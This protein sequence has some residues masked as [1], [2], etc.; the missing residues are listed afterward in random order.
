MLLV[1]FCFWWNVVGVDC[2]LCIVFYYCMV[3]QGGGGIDYVFGFGGV[4]YVGQLYDYV[5]GILVLDDW[6][7]YVELVYV[8]VQGVDV[9]FDGV[10]GDLCDFGFWYGDCDVVV[11]DVIVE[12]WLCFDQGGVGM[13]CGVIVGGWVQVGYDVVVGVV[14]Y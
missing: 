12:C 7:G 8:V 14:F 1:Y 5:V 9:L 2:V 10:V 6:F 3:F 11:V 4:L 13:L